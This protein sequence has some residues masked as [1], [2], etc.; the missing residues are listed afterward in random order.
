M[1]FEA[2]TPPSLE[3]VWVKLKSSSDTAWR[4]DIVVGVVYFPPRCPYG[5]EMC[6][7]I[8]DVV[9][10]VRALSNS[11]TLLIAGDFNDLDTQP[12]ELHTLLRQVVLEPTRG[13]SILDKIF[14][15]MGSDYREPTTC[16]PLGKSDH[17]IVSLQPLTRQAPRQNVNF[18]V[19]PHR[20]SSVRSFG[21]WITHANWSDVDE[22]PDASLQ[23]ERLQEILTARYHSHFDEVS[24][25]RRVN[26][27]VW[28]NNRIRRLITTRNDHHDR[29]DMQSYKQ[30]RNVVQREISQAKKN[31]GARKVHHLRRTEPGK[32]HQQIKGLTGMRKSS[33]SKLASDKM[34]AEFAHELNCHFASI[35]NRLPSLD[36]SA[37]PAYLPS[38]PPP[39]INRHEVYKRLKKLNASKAG[40]PGDIPIRLIK[41]FAYEI[42]EP[43]TT[44]FNNCLQTG[45][46][47]SCWKTASV[48]PVP[49]TTPVV[50][51]SQLRPLSITPI[52]ARVF[53]GFLA[54]WMMADVKPMIRPTA[55]W[56]YE[57]QFCEPLSCEPSR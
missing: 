43:L 2:N 4:H 39:K 33:V 45:H 10:L 49:K 50:D 27:K 57:G 35:C 24:I 51:F 52:L 3:I 26:D 42:S 14:T 55:I 6:D 54:E 29:G 22:Q 19:R 23:A 53:E 16:A 36:V 30:A 44:I 25:K 20:D 8:V 40:H 37:L 11:T 41:E 47:P 34:P 48:C 5:D 31:F 38:L 32:W 56:E 7:H 18:S 21:Q 9:D 17:L 15:D 28:M 12:I 13:N 1:V 46:F